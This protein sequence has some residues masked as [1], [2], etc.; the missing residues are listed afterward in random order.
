MDRLQTTALK[1]LVSRMYISR[2]FYRSQMQ[3]VGLL[4]EDVQTLADIAKLPFT[5][6]QDMR[7]NYP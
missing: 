4:P 6:K 1:D 2:K 7:D 3:E 5:T